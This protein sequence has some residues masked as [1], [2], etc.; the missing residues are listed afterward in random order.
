MQA[1]RRIRFIHLGTAGVSVDQAGQYQRGWIERAF[2]AGLHYSLVPMRDSQ[3]TVD[4]LAGLEGTEAEQFVEWTVVR[5]DWF[6]DGDV[7]PYL[8]DET[9]QSGIF[10]GETSRIANIADFIGKLVRDSL[11]W[12]TWKGKMPVIRDA[13]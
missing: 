8:L 7:S 5:P 4:Y 2:I 9:I 3:A 6:Q 12:E 1:K 10:A 11:V 13:K